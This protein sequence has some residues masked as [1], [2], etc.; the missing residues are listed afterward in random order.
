MNYYNDEYYKQWYHQLFFSFTEIISTGTILYLC[1]LTHE[2]TQ[3]KLG[4]IM[5][6]ALIHVGVAGV[7]Q[8]VSNVLQGEGYSHQV[9]N[10][11]IMRHPL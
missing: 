9:T 11:T 2:I 8:F 1:N 5:G 3:P 7:D 10:D 6:I 4:V